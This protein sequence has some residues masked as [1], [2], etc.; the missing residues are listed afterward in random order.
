MLHARPTYLFES[1][2]SRF[3]LSFQ[4]FYNQISKFIL[5]YESRI[6]TYVHNNANV[7]YYHFFHVFSIF[8]NLIYACYEKML[9]ELVLDSKIAEFK[10]FIEHCTTS[11]ATYSR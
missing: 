5:A 1:N 7:L 4:I 10:I 6:S 9:K 8:G 11:R 2:I 3:Q